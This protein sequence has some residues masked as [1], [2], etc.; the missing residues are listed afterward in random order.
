MRSRD[1]RRRGWIAF[2]IA[3][4]TVMSACSSGGDTAPTTSAAAS[5]SPTT[6]LPDEG[7][8][9]GPQVASFQG[10][11]L[12][13]GTASSDPAT[14]TAVV[15]GT[16]LDQAAIDAVT[17][18]LP[19]WTTDAATAAFN[20]PA[21]T[22][23]PPQTGAV[24]DRPFPSTDQAPP[25]E[26]VPSGPL[27]VV[28]HQPDGAV[29]VAPFVSITFDQPMV[30][31]GTVGQL[32]AEVVPAT[33]VPDVPGTWQW[34]GTTT[35]RFDAAVEGIDRL[36][37]ATDY[38]VTIPAGTVSATGGT[39]AEDVSWTFSTP[40]PQVVS[41]QPDDDE[42]LPLTPLFLA[43]FDQR[44]DPTG[45]PR[46]RAPERRRC[47]ARRA[48]G[49]ERRGRRRPSRA[50]GG[51]LAAR[52]SLAGVPSGRP[53]AGRR[54]DR[55]RARPRRP[56]RRGPAHHERHRF[57]PR[58]HVR[59]AA[60]RGGRVRVG[61]RL[62]TAG[63]DHDHDEQ[64]D[65]SRPVRPGIDRRRSVDRRGIDRC[66]RRHDQHLR[67]DGAGADVRRDRA[68]RPD[69]RV[70]AAAG[71]RRHAHASPLVRRRPSSV[72]FSNR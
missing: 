7:P 43:V 2:G 62:R 49:D 14:P 71:R 42:S 8:D 55:R 20:W 57:V 28:R 50:A 26:T 10:V 41:F 6:T 66:L 67:A 52:G 12:T 59:T 13:R 68:R 11:R 38:T 22:L 18:R 32:A 23:Q 45:G 72:R 5:T 3:I 25:D 40:S 65:R 1:E 60:G 34:I 31:V 37:M 9:S 33:L 15:A 44:I 35:L 53:A 36:P 54:G 64:R 30:P 21:Q 17:G 56:V 69:R 16:A 51:R 61:R 46:C 63:R 19:E 29:D 39:L 27:Q 24:V 48:V 58:A 47:T 70:R 4:A